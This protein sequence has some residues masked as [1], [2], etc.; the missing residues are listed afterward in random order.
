MKLRIWAI[1]LTAALLLTTAGCGVEEKPVK[2]MPVETVTLPEIPAP[3]ASVPQTAAPVPAA[4]AQQAPAPAAQRLT[5][6]EAEALALA[7]AGFAAD[8]VTHLRSEYEI[9]DGVPHY[10]VEFRVD[11]REY[12]YEIHA[13]TGAV[14]SFE[15]DD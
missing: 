5:V 14:L 13:E 15:K 9:D 4:P 2:T 7:H 3:T 10:D 1:L 8:Q 11:R 12:D 6:E